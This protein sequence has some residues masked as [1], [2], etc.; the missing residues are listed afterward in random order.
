MGRGRDVEAVLITGVFGVG[1]S[2]VT[3]EIADLLEE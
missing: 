1:K 2:P 3:A